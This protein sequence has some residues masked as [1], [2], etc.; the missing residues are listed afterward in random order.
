MQE[1]KCLTIPVRDVK[2]SPHWKVTFGIFYVGVF[3]PARGVPPQAF[4]MTNRPDDLLHL[5]LDA[6]EKSLMQENEPKDLTKDI[7]HA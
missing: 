5:I 7:R 4:S 1:Q 6:L 2:K 3:A